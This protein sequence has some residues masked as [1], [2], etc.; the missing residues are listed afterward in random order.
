MV[1]AGKV[2]RER[3]S[4]KRFSRFSFQG[5]RKEVRC[6]GLKALR[7]GVHR[8]E[9]GKLNK[10]CILPNSAPD[11]RDFDKMEDFV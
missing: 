10:I 7:R 5:E 11:R 6:A 2:K 3:E 4:R 8:S 9:Y 1:G